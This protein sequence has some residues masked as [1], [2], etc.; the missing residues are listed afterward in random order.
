MK[1]FIEIGSSHFNTLRYLCDKGWKGIMVDPIK[2]ALD[3]VPNHIALTK[4]NLGIH[5]KPG[6]YDFV[7]IKDEKFFSW[8]KDYQGSA[9][10]SNTMNFY[11]H[12]HPDKE[13]ISVSCITF[14]ELCSQNKVSKIDYLKLDTEGMDLDILK[15]IDFDKY[16]IKFIRAEHN[17]ND[18]RK[19]ETKELLESKGYLVESFQE[20]LVGVKI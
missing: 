9:T 15:S 2:I 17:G 11:E 18:I 19:K 4:I 8:E 12:Q 5:P 20:D 7:K 1:Q 10:F 16:Q 3:K 6:N 14:N 13:K